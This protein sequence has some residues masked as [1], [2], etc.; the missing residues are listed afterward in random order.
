MPL[1]RNRAVFGFF[2]GDEGEYPFPPTVIGR[3]DRSKLADKQFQI[4]GCNNALRDC[5]NEGNIVDDH[6][7]IGSHLGL[8]I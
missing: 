1:L 2:G 4:E 8:I 5:L 3:P 7:Q 6:K